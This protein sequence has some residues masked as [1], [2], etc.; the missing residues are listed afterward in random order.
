[1]PQLVCPL[2]DNTS[3][4]FF[5]TSLS[6]CSLDFAALLEY[7]SKSRFRYQ[8][9]KNREVLLNILCRTNF[10]LEKSLSQH[11]WHF[12]FTKYRCTRAVEMYVSKRTETFRCHQN[13]AAP[14]NPKSVK[15]FSLAFFFLERHD[16]PNPHGKK[17]ALCENHFNILKS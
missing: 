4:H 3:F 10:L 2:D 15:K 7:R 8:L 1:M 16:Q 6:A 14:T 17:I 12:F 13:F 5:F 9:D 11:S